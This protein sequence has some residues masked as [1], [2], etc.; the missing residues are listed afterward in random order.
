MRA[1]SRNCCWQYHCLLSARSFII[2]PDL[3]LEIQVFKTLACAQIDTLS[4]DHVF[5]VLILLISVLPEL[6]QLYGLASGHFDLMDVLTAAIASLLA[7]II[8]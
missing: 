8:S 2:F 1:S 6:L 5:L 7:L 3:L 4:Q